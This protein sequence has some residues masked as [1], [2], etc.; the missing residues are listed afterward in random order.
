[1]RAA[2][3]KGELESWLNGKQLNYIKIQGTCYPIRE[4][5]ACLSVSLT[6]GQSTAIK[7]SP[8]DVL[9]KHSFSLLNTFYWF[10]LH[11]P[12]THIERA[13]KRAFV[14]VRC[15][16]NLS[17]KHE[18]DVSRYS[19]SAHTHTRREIYVLCTL[20][21]RRMSN[22]SCLLFC[23]SSMRHTSKLAYDVT[24]VNVC[25]TPQPIRMP[26]KSRNNPAKNKFQ[27]E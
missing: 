23:L 26:H 20:A 8:I 5:S 9:S 14:S 1:M 7:P 2:P 24:W 10:S 12:R 21:T 15:L 17:D 3:V 18:C 25:F 16:G 13:R 4:T 22:V 19:S 27:I 11:H 6:P